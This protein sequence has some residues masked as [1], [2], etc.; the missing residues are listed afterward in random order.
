MIISSGIDINQGVLILPP[1]FY[2]IDV[3]L[4]GGGGGGGAASAWSPGTTNANGGGGGAGGYRYISGV[5]VQ[6]GVEY[7][8]IIGEGG[9]G[10]FTTGGGDINATYTE[11][12]DG[13][14][15]TAF[16]YSAAG[17]GLG[18]SYTP[19]N[20]ITAGRNGG[21]GG[22]G[23]GAGSG[24]ARSGGLGNTPSTT[25]SQGNNGGSSYGNDGNGASGGGGGAGGVGTSGAPGVGG[26][27]GAGKYPDIWY[28]STSGVFV[29][30]GG[31]GS[32]ATSGTGGVGGGGNATRTVSPFNA[33]GTNGL[34]GGGGGKGAGVGQGGTGGSG[35]ILLRY[36]SGLR[37]I[38]GS[39]YIPGDG[40]T[41]H[42]FLVSSIFRA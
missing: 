30:G 26:N 37:A 4:I 8:L 24:Q 15:S 33:N 25:P 9:I 17:G 13:S 42:D 31:G 38:G 16:G 3:M 7:N 1:Q 20:G 35:R 10:S 32:G 34:G 21:S 19:I 39:I 27:G 14:T 11:G 41:Y 6:S 22:G 29:C 2:T 5:V 28:A 18:G 23:G 40:Y 12:T 36:Q